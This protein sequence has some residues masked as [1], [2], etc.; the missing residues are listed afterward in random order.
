MTTPPPET[1]IDWHCPSLEV[2]DDEILVLIH[3]PGGVDTA[4]R[5][6]TVW[7]FACGYTV[8]EPI[9]HWAHL[10]QP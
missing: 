6:G 10:P 9:L 5:D 7:R 8:R 1:T 2:P 4:F 3:L